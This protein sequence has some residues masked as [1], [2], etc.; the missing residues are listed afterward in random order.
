MASQRDIDGR[1]P[2]HDIHDTPDNRS[3]QAQSHKANLSNPNTSEKS[4]KR[5]AEALQS[6][7]GEDA[8]YSKDEAEKKA[9]GVAPK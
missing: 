1:D 8:F 6:L 7:G 4:K 3:H 2:M 9:D 5:S